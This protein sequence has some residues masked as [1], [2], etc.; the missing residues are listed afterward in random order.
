MSNECKHCEFN[1]K[2]IK[3][4]EDLTKELHAFNKRLVEENETQKKRIDYLELPH[5]ERTA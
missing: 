2:I 1:Y 5:T 4:Y 3:E